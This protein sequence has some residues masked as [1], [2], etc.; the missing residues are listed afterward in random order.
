MLVISVE[1]ASYKLRGELSRW[2]VEVKNGVFAG[3][4][5][6]IIRDALWRKVRC[7][8]KDNGAVMIYSADNE[9]GFCV[10]IH[11]EPRRNLVDIDGIRLVKI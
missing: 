1:N 3:K 9:Q 4:A 5:N 11:G 2:L 8:Q 10:E 7:S 6:P